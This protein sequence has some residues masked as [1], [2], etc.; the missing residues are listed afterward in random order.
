[1]NNSEST[2]YRTSN[3]KHFQAPALMSDG[4]QFTDYRQSYD[5][6]N[7]QPEG[8]DTSFNM[9]MYLTHNAEKIMKQN[10]NQAYV[11]NG[12]FNCKKP[13]VW[14]TMMQPKYYQ[15]CNTQ[16]CTRTLNDPNGVG[17]VIKN[18]ENSNCTAPLEEPEY[19]LIDNKCAPIDSLANYYPVSSKGSESVKRNASPGGGKMLSG[20][21][22]KV[23]A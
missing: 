14:G 13:Y 8:V 10:N 6:N 5:M 18:S 3:N 15:E 12:L 7:L 2:C 23:Y 20:G 1:M 19:T 9:R 22:P 21:D 11:K 16:F 17:L 4:R